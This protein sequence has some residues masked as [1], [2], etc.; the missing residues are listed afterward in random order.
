MK[1]SIGEKRI[2]SIMNKDKI[3]F[4]PKLVNTIDEQYKELNFETSTK[5]SEFID[6]TFFTFQNNSESL[7][8]LY[9]K[10]KIKLILK[11]KDDMIYPEDNDDNHYIDYFKE[12][13]DNFSKTYKKPKRKPKYKMKSIKLNEEIEPEK[14][15]QLYK[16]KIKIEYLQETYQKTRKE[17]LKIVNFFKNKELGF[18]KKKRSKKSI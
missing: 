6:N 2:H 5:C 3:L 4:L 10:R 15:Y 14:I 18:I 1:I 9:L 11:I 7:K 13:Y 12:K 8:K 16:N 17:I